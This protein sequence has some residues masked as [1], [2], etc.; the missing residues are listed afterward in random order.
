MHVTMD[1]NIKRCTAKWKTALVVEII[2]GKT[3][4]AEASR[5]FNLSPFEIEGGVEDAK[6]GMENSLRANPLD[7][8]EQD[9]TQRPI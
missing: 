8:C 1:E 7:I 6:R 3:I 4:V 2:V 5:S 9:E